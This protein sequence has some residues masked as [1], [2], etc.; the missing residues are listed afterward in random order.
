MKFLLVAFALMF[1]AP[2]FAQTAAGPS[3]AMTPAPDD[4]AKQWLTLVDDKNYTDAYKQLSATA[5]AKSA[6]GAW[7]QK[8]GQTREPLGAMAS[9]TIKDVKLTKIRPGMGDGQ[10][11]M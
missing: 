5:Q 2:A 3:T 1:A 10:D 7:A 11:A 6:A 8:I 4:R 9:R